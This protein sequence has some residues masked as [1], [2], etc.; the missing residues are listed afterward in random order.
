MSGRYILSW[1]FYDFGWSLKTLEDPERFLPG[2]TL[3]LHCFLCRVLSLANKC[4]SL[5]L[6]SAKYWI[7]LIFPDHNNYT[8]LITMAD[9]GKG[10]GSLLSNKT[11]RAKE[12][13]IVVS[14]ISR[15]Q[16]FW[17]FE[18]IP[19]SL[20]PSPWVKTSCF[21]VFHL[22]LG[23]KSIQDLDMDLETRPQKIHHHPICLFLLFLVY[24]T[25][26]EV[27]K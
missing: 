20:N 17:K 25:K 21:F 14:I 15:N 4:I 8:H 13:V 18:P 16:G 1:A 2:D 19:K 3:H 7:G 12:V 27:S 6:A 22:S 26:M 24:H 10:S 9:I 23:L 5:S 11:G